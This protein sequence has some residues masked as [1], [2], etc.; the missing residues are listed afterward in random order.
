M[1][2]AVTQAA[3]S[4]VD[5]TVGNVQYSGADTE[6]GGSLSP[7]MLQV[8]F[9]GPASA[10]SYNVSIDWGDGSQPTTF[11]LNPGQTEFD[12]PLPQYAN[13]GSYPITVTVTDAEDNSA[14]NTTPLY[15]TYSNSAPSSLTLSLGQTTFQ[16]GS[17][18]P[19]LSGSFTDPQPNIAHVVTIDWGD[20]TAS[21]GPDT[22]TV[23]LAPG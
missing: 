21:S 10:E 9:T 15:V 11:S 7:E 22:T 13:N 12:Y 1:G 5:V 14:S 16:A 20:E 17:G 4:G 18:G 23:D 19:D 6:E 3:P 2:V 8:H